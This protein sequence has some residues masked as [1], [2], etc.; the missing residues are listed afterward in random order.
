ML[1]PY[2]PWMLYIQCLPTI[3]LLKAEA[4]LRGEVSKSIYQCMVYGCRVDA[5]VMDRWCNWL[6]VVWSFILI[7]LCTFFTLVH[8]EQLGLLVASYLS[9][10]PITQVLHYIYNCPLLYCHCIKAFVLKLENNN[11]ICQINVKV[12]VYLLWPGEVECKLSWQSFQYFASASR[13]SDPCCR[14]KQ[15]NNSYM[16]SNISILFRFQFKQ[17]RKVGRIQI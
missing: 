17:R 15:D 13:A 5:V 1:P 12:A 8:L 3:F 6:V 14:V 9:K 11:F 2:P 10:R 7:L 4:P 16:T